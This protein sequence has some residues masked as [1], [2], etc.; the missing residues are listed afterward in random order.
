[1]E[2]LQAHCHVLVNCKAVEQFVKYYQEDRFR[3]A[4]LDEAL[5]AFRQDTTSDFKIP[6]SSTFTSN[7]ARPSQGRGRGKGRGGRSQTGRGQRSRSK[8]QCSYCSQ[9]GH[10]V[11]NCYKKHGYPPNFKQKFE[12]N[13]NSP[14]LNCM[15][16]VD[17]TEDVLEDLSEH[18]NQVARGEITSTEFTL[19]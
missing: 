12:N 1:M 5:Y 18:H 16:A 10:T 14:I 15:T 19:E 8:L 4:E 11:D 6:A 3:V 9:T 17:N 2:T 7:T 13:M